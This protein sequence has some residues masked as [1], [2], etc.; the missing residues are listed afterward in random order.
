MVLSCLDDPAELYPASIACADMGDPF[1]VN[2][3]PVS[4]SDGCQSDLTYE[5]VSAYLTSGS[6]PGTWVRH[7]VAYDE[8]GNVSAEES[9]SVHPD[10]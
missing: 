3:M 9:H 5:V 4:A 1:D 8:S 2:F 7:W 10:L 6:C